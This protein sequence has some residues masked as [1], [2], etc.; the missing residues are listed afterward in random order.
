LTS[1][2]DYSE[3]PNNI[4][5]SPEQVENSVHHFLPYY[6]KG[7]RDKF[8]FG[9]SGFAYKEGIAEESA[10]KILENICIRTDDT[11]KNSRLETLHRTYV[12]GPENGFDGITGKTKLKEPLYLIVM[13]GVLKMLLKIHLRF[14]MPATRNKASAEK[15]SPL[16]AAQSTYSLFLHLSNISSNKVLFSFRNAYPKPAHDSISLVN[17]SLSELML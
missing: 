2:D 3:S 15:F 12:N 13:T 1:T 6:C 16:A 11:E 9:F 10:S 8:A 4:V 17:M 5:L 14:G 7:T